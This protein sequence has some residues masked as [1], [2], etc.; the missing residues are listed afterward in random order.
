MPFYIFH[1]AEETLKIRKKIM[2]KSSFGILGVTYKKDVLDLRRTPT[3]TVIEE[4]CQVSKNVMTFDPLT[5]ENFGANTGSLEETISNKDCIILLVDHSF[6]RN[7]KIEEKIN[8]LS[9]KC[10][11]I[12]ARNF[13]D[14]KKLKKSILYRCLGKPFSS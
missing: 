5:S 1:L 12:D 11:L 7:N 13:I 10:C 4:L 3:K 6:F 8:N 2:N 9:P 14:S